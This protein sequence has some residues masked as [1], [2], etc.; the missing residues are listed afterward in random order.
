MVNYLY[1]FHIPIFFFLSGIF[2]NAGEN[3]AS[4]LKCKFFSILLPFYIFEIFSIILYVLVEYR[5]RENI[6]FFYLLLV[7]FMLLLLM[8]I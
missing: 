7:F 2:F 8:D 4:F 1:S 5:F 3:L 6:S